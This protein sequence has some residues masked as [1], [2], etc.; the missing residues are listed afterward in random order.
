MA[1]TLR[2]GKELKSKEKAEKE[3]NEA[4]TEKTYQNSTN[5]ERKL[6][7]NG[8]LDETGQMKKK[9]EVA[10]DEAVQKEEVRIYQPLVSFPQRLQ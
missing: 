1:I 9:G 5:S 8:L 2:S 3:H 6:N 7:I 10:K 4:E